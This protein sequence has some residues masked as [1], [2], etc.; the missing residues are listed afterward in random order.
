MSRKTKKKDYPAAEFRKRLRR[1]REAGVI[2]DLEEVALSEARGGSERGRSCQG[3]RRQSAAQGAKTHDGGLAGS[4]ERAGLRLRPRIR[5]IHPDREVK[6]QDYRRAMTFDSD[7]RRW[8]QF[9][10]QMRFLTETALADLDAETVFAGQDEAPAFRITL[11]AAASSQGI[12]L[13]DTEI[14]TEGRDL[15]ILMESGEGQLVVKLQLLGIAALED[16][17]NREARFKSANGAINY[18]F[19]FSESGGATCLFSD[20]PDIRA[21]LQ[22]FAIFIEPKQIAPRE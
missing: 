22:D 13:P 5:R 9:A 17:A 2:D 18:R 8:R 10:K 12:E 15:S 21:G 19:C 20:S 4:D 16:Y 11:L 14:L 7:K 6:A 3:S 1:C